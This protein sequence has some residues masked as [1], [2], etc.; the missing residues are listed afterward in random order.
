MHFFNITFFKLNTR[1][2]LVRNQHKPT[3][4]IPSLFSNRMNGYEI[5]NDHVNAHQKIGSRITTQHIENLPIQII[6]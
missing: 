4:Q 3:A 5:K 2:N 1:I 6:Q